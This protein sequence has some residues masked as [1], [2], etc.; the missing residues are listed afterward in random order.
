MQGEKVN[1]MHECMN[2]AHKEKN[3]TL[4]TPP[5]STLSPPLSSNGKN[6]TKN[7]MGE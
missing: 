4:Y 3:E 6:K 2:V 7:P 5:E 1:M